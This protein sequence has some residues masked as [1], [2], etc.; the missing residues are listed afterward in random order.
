MREA[1]LKVGGGEAIEP[2]L[3]KHLAQFFMLYEKKKEESSLMWDDSSFLAL[4]IRD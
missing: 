4:L 1:F 2:V 3:G